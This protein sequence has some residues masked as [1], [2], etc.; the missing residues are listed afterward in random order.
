[1]EG[2]LAVK[3]ILERCKLAEQAQK[4]QQEAAY[5]LIIAAMEKWLVTQEHWE[6]P[7]EI[8]L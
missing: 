4:A 2:T 3:E 6:E 8:P 7:L 5:K 1:M